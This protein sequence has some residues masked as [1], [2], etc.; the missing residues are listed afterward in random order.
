MIWRIRWLVV[1][2]GEGTVDDEVAKKEFDKLSL[3][4]DILYR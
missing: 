1:F 3:N 2:V 4:V